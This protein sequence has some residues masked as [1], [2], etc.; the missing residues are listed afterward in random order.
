LYAGNRLFLIC[1]NKEGAVTQWEIDDKTGAVR[2]SAILLFNLKAKEEVTGII[3][4]YVPPPT[5]YTGSSRNGS[6][7]Y[8]VVEEDP[9]KEKGKLLEGVVFDRQLNKLSTFSFLTP[10]ELNGDRLA[11]EIVLSDK[12][13]LSMIYSAE[14]SN[15]KGDYTPLAYSV[16]QVDKKGSVS[17]FPLSGQPAGLLV[18]LDCCWRDDSLFL[19]GWLAPVKNG[20]ARQ[21]LQGALVDGQKKLTNVRTVDISSLNNNLHDNVHGQIGELPV[22]A[23]V[24]YSFAMPDGS[25]VLVMEVSGASDVIRV[26]TYANGA[27]SHMGSFTRSRGYVFILKMDRTGAPAWLSAISKSQDDAE[28]VVEAGIACTMSD[29]GDLHVFFYD[30]AKNKEPLSPHPANT[31]GQDFKTNELACVSVAPDGSMKKQ[32][33]PLD[34]HEFRMMPEKAKPLHN[35]EFVFTRLHQKPSFSPAGVFNHGTFRFGV[36]RVK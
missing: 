16:V 10:E 25:R 12:G 30:R 23:K 32:F 7:Y 17:H 13:D 4:G 19:T 5:Y 6:F 21:L 18:N 24:R 20:N 33:I 11:P 2:G 27:M 26:T 34:D 1:S 22:S 28:F 31:L 15:K 14:V 8:L 35:N 29:E 3:D 36:I 9:K